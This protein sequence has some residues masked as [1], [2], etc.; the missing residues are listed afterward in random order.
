MFL[1]SIRPRSALGP[2]PS[3]TVVT[4]NISLV[5][6]R[7]GPETD[8]LMLRLQILV[9]IPPLS[10]SLHPIAFTLAQGQLDFYFSGD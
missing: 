6:M 10:L 1:V 2:T 8:N 3:F 7:P 4:V 9:A 5:L